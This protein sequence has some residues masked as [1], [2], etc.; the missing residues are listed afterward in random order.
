MCLNTIDLIWIT[1]EVQ[2]RDFQ[3]SKKWLENVWAF[4]MD[5]SYVWIV[6]DHYFHDCTVGAGLYATSP[7]RA[8]RGP[9]YELNLR[10]RSRSVLTNGL[11]LRNSFLF[12][13]DS[14]II[15]I[16]IVI[17]P[18]RACARGLVCVSVTTL[19]AAS[20]VFRYKV[21]HQ[22]A[23]YNTRKKKMFCSMACHSDP[24]YFL[25]TKDSLLTS[26]YKTSIGVW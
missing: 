10:D 25:M 11:W 6:S 16:I 9:M 1:S 23:L 26:K 7:H 13:L 24:G 8:A 4:C 3:Q 14:I 19:E 5:S 15:I 22:Q 20:F 2:L 12:T 17:N 18:R 21:I